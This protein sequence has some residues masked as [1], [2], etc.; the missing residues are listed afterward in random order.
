LGVACGDDEVKEVNLCE[1][2]VCDVNYP[3]S[4]CDPLDGLCKCGTGDDRILCKSGEACEADP[5]PTCIETACVGVHCDNGQV[6]DP[7][8]GVCK[9]G[10]STCTGDEECVQ[11]RCVIRN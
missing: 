11:N 2:V 8:D 9:C 3:G 7:T 10:T 6:C 4:T 5:T 1:G